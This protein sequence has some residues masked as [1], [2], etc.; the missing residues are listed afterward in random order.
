MPRSCRSNRHKTGVRV[1]H[2]HQN[3]MVRSAT[4]TSSTF[5][6]QVILDHIG[7][8]NDRWSVVEASV[9]LE[10]YIIFLIVKLTLPL[11]C[12]HSSGLWPHYYFSFEF[13]QIWSFCRESNGF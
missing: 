4:F 1:N 13:R 6:F 10:R 5:G 12:V 7:R 2:N 3:D 8:A 9:R 11:A